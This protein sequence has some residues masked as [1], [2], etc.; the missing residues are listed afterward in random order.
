MEQCIIPV[1][2]YI[3]GPSALLSKCTLDGNCRGANDF[4]RRL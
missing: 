3:I 4:H 1:S 2:S